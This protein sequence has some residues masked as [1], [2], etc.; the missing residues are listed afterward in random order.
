MAVSIKLLCDAV[1]PSQRGE[2]RHVRRKIH[3]A[4]GMVFQHDNNYRMAVSGNCLGEGR[5]QKQQTQNK[6]QLGF[7][8]LPGSAFNSE[9]FWAHGRIAVARSV[10][11]LYP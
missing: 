7:H 8:R 5:T 3:A 6:R 2:I 9:K 10:D 4:V 11:Q 1:L